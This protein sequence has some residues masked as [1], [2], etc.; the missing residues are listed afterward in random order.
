MSDDEK[1]AKEAA[2]QQ[3]MAQRWADLMAHSRQVAETFAKGRWT[4]DVFSIVHPPDLIK[5]FMEAGK[6]IM[7][8]PE[9]LVHAQ[10]QLYRDSLELWQR[11]MQQM[12]GQA[13]APVIE[14][15]RGDRRFKDQAW[16]ED[17]LFDYVKQSYLLTSRW[18][19]EVV[20]DAEGLD[21]KTREKVD[22][23][24]RQ[25]LSALAPSN[26]AVTNPAVLRRIRETEGK[27]L[28]KGLEHML[29][30]LD[31]GQGRLQLSMTDEAAFEVGRNIATTPG[32]VIFQNELMQL[33]QYEAATER[34]YKRPFLLVPPWINKFYV[35]DLQPKN[36]LIKW[37][38]DQGH[39]VFVI[40]WV[41]PGPDLA[42]KGFSDYM[43]EGPLAALDAVEQATGET[44]VNALG[45]CI[46][47]I[48]TSST[49]A[50]MAAKGD[51]RI[52]SA[53]LLATMIDLTE[54]G[55]AAVFIDEAQLERLEQHVAEKGYLEGHH[56][57]AMFN[58]M[59][60]NDLIWSFVVNNYLLGRDPAAL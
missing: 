5:A 60:E 30:D 12:A 28:I 54:V 56:M 42:H 33:I 6:G 25:Y 14:P 37:L 45:F 7:A 4:E 43:H 29:E 48:L 9:K 26:F 41:N 46:G 1:A 21:P 17:V 53:T 40:S 15:E 31:R 35:L 10:F 50:Y 19:K 57:A 23:F 38:V 18:V 55:E 59:R 20:H 8:D 49:L 13:V 16:S 58:M 52:S 36:S 27:S 47:G 34:V 51:R 2:E 39:S 44:E 11:M 32:K 22:F 3:E 24:T